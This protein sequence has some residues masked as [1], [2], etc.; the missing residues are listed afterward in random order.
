MA[1]A[2]PMIIQKGWVISAGET[3]DGY[4]TEFPLREDEVD[5]ARNGSGYILFWGKIVYRDV[6][7]E[8]HKSGWCRAY[9]FESEG[10]R[11]AGD[12]S[13]NYYT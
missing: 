5:R 11:F 10:W 7:K 2:W 4:S 13:L 3:Q 12:N 1:T 6:F 9:H 8:V